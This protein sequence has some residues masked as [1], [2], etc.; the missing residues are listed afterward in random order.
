VGQ[1]GGYAPLELGRA[2]PQAVNGAPVG[3]A[4]NSSRPRSPQVRPP[5]AKPA[6]HRDGLVGDDIFDK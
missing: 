3:H 5:A 6:H 4:N 2:P 1:D